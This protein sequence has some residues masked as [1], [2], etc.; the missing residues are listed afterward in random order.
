MITVVA[1]ALLLQ[2]SVIPHWQFRSSHA[3]LFVVLMLI[4]ALR[5]PWED[6][7]RWVFLG[8]ILLDLFS[9]TPFGLFSVAALLTLVSARIWYDRAF[10]APW[11]MA[12]LLALPY[13]IVFNMI[14]VFILQWAGYAVAWMPTL[15]NI[16]IPAAVWNM[17]LMAVIYPL[18]T[19]LTR[20]D[21]PVS[22]RI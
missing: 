8:G 2:L 17:G 6:S 7:L 18:V 10:G 1:I 19:R 3:N 13:S 16:V 12:V 22:L 5:L 21:T 14:V 20:L 9:P 11:L 4:W 15:L